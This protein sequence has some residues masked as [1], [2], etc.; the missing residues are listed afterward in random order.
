LGG[1]ADGVILEVDF[2]LLPD[3]SFTIPVAL[4]INYS[5]LD[6]DNDKKL[7]NYLNLMVNPD[8]QSRD[9]QGN[10][11]VV[12]NLSQHY[13]KMLEKDPSFKDDVPYI[14]MI[15]E[16]AI[17]S[18]DDQEDDSG[19][20]EFVIVT[21]TQL[22]F[23]GLFDNF[24]PIPKG[25]DE[26]MNKNSVDVARM[27]VQMCYGL[28]RIH[29]NGFIHKD[30]HSG[31]I[32]VAGNPDNFYPMIIDFDH[33]IKQSDFISSAFPIRKKMLN[34]SS[35]N[36]SE[37]LKYTEDPNYLIGTN[38]TAK[39][40]N[41]VMVETSLFFTPEWQEKFSKFS[42]MF[43]ANVKYIN[44]TNTLILMLETVLIPFIRMKLINEDHENIKR[45]KEQ[46]NSIKYQISFRNFFS[47]HEVFE[48]LN[49]ASGLNLTEFHPV[50]EDLKSYLEKIRSS[51]KSGVPNMT[52]ELHDENNERNIL[53]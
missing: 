27:I 18:F 48:Q 12:F 45:L 28:W 17:I 19:I 2:Q 43:V 38:E 49:E 14:S 31:N 52:T 37:N 42:W 29:D 7:E 47:S 39:D 20:T 6:S 4:K 16:G 30:I 15:Y 22:G 8:D 24:L 23:A 5:N 46:I 53:V 41:N 44:D 25:S 21:V 51:R 11:L 40:F 32:I 13:E 26:V 1:G 35:P 3:H 33:L 10:D 9:K 34:P 36:Y 50:N